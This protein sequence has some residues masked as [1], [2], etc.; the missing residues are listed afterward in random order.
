V[1]VVCREVTFYELPEQIR[2][3]DIAAA[4]SRS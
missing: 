3:Q 1:F 4:P 2:K